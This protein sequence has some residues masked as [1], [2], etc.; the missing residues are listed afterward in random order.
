MAK[1]NAVSLPENVWHPGIAPGAESRRE[2]FAHR[3]IT[4]AE[5]PL[6]FCSDGSRSFTANGHQEW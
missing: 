1:E 5:R 4:A 6:P 3:P 2:D